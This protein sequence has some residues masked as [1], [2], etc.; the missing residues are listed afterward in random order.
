V[1]IGYRIS[2][3]LALVGALLAFA[4]GAY[5]LIV[6][7]HEIFMTPEGITTATTS[8]TLAGLVPLGIGAIAVLAVRTRRTRSFWLAAALAVAAAVMFLFSISLQLAPIAAFLVLAAAVRTVT[9]RDIQ[10]R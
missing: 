1:S 2:N 9:S 7:P 4:F 6:G 5:L 8:P 3:G 10:E